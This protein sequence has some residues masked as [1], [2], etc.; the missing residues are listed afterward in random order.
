MSQSFSAFGASQEDSVGSWNKR[1][2]P[3]G[4][5]SAS[6]SKVKHFP[7]AATILLRTASENFRPTTVNLGTTSIL[8]SSTTLQTHTIVLF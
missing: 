3:V 8:S 1:E 6:W 2:V 4:D 5:F 7:P